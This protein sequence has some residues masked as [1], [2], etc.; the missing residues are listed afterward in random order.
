MTD[1]QAHIATLT[2]ALQEAEAKLAMVTAALECIP[3]LEIQA[4]EFDAASSKPIVVRLSK[5]TVDLIADAVEQTK[6]AV[7]AFL[8][9]VKRQGAAKELRVYVRKLQD[10]ASIAA[11]PNAP[12]ILLKVAE[13]LERRA[14]ELEAQ[15]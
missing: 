2:A 11:N 10:S 9:R 4:I 7:A 15:S 5:G 3:Y 6:P 14:A 12:P 13:A 8:D 1:P